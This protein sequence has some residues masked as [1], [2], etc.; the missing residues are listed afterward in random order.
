MIA[1]SDTSAIAAAVASPDRSE[2]PAYFSASSPAAFAQR[3]TISATDWSVSRVAAMLAWRSTLR[4]IG[5]LAMAATSSQ[6][7][8]VRTG[9][10]RGFEPNG[11]PTFLPSPSWSVFERRS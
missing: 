1:R 6:A 2:C 8:S 7:R 4:K 9:K 11:N 10:V 3:L 5:A